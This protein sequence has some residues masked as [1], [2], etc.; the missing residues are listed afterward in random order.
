VPK[1]LRDKW[2]ASPKWDGYEDVPQGAAD[3]ALA[4]AR[5]PARLG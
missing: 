1:A 4:R 3:A 2:A 5:W